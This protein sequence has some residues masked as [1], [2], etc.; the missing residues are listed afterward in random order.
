MTKPFPLYDDLVELCDVV[1]AMGAGAFRGTGDISIEQDAKGSDE[2]EE[3]GYE[4]LAMSEELAISEDWD[5]EE[6]LVHL[7]SSVLRILDK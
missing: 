4:G 7:I 2:E 6:P 3:E 5:I 1:I